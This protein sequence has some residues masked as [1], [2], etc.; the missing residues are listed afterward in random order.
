MEIM[1]LNKMLPQF[2]FTV[3][4][5]NELRSSSDGNK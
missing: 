3:Y 2:G 5:V 1:I 4:F